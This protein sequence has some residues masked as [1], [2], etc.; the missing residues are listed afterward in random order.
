MDVGGQSCDTAAVPPGKRQANPFYRRLSMPQ[1]RCGRVWN[2]SPSPRIH[3]RTAQPV[4]SR[5]AD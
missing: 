5:Y 4:A 1:G 2:T 3:P